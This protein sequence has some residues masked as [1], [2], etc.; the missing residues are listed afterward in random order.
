MF[1]TVEFYERENSLKERL[2]RLFTGE[3]ITAER[4][5]L[6]ENEFFYRLK[7]PLHKGKIPEERLKRLASSLT[8][9][10]IFPDWYRCDGEIK[11][12][13]SSYFRDILLFNSAVSQI[14]KSVFNPAETLIT[15]ID[16]KGVLHSEIS[17]LVNF[18]GEIKVITDNVRAY[19]REAERIMGEYGL[20]LFVSD[21]LS[22]IPDRG[23]II[24]RHSEAVPVYFKGLLITEEKRLL[25]FARVLTGEGIKAKGNYESLCPDGINMTDFLSALCEV[26]FL[27]E[28]RKS[29]YEKLVDISI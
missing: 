27:K 28:L 21:K 7:V 14:E 17:R 24:S 11:R 22:A 23:I 16:K 20:S 4:I 26:C 9:G 10:L 19:G 2:K 1:G 18:A 8:D 6:P 13:A 12:Y 29:E 15:V 3:R 25:P 5:N